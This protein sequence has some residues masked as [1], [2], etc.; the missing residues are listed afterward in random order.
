MRFGDEFLPV[1]ISSSEAESRTVDAPYDLI[2]SSYMFLYPVNEHFWYDSAEAA[3]CTT[4]FGNCRIVKP[5]PPATT[6]V[7]ATMA[8]EG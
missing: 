1:R 6:N 5:E 2:R 8:A 3:P 7:H 4:P